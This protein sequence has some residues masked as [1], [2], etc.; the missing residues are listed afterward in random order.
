MT[1]LFKSMTMFPTSHYENK[2]M[3]KYTA[4]S[5]EAFVEY[6][7][8]KIQ[9]HRVSTVTAARISPS[10]STASHH[11]VN[12]IFKIYFSVAIISLTQ[13]LIE[14]ITLKTAFFPSKPHVFKSI[15]LKAVNS[16]SKMISDMKMW[17]AANR[18]E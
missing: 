4:I 14:L 7:G 1:K 16:P 13:W 5:L 3:L 8:R 10:D 17:A 11:H 6:S 18:T 12:E 9:V 2:T 15:I